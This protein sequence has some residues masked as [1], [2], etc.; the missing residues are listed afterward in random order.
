MMEICDRDRQL[1]SLGTK[2]ET[3]QQKSG[4]LE[5]VNLQIEEMKKNFDPNGDKD[6][7]SWI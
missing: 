3:K 1:A 5:K 4:Y 7:H 6:K 2:F